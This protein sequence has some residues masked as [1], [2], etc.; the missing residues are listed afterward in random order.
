MQLRK[1]ICIIT[2]A[3]H[4]LKDYNYIFANCSFKSFSGC[5]HI[6]ICNNLFQKDMQVK[7]SVLCIVFIL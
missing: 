6:Y 5:I 7:K 2:Y 4:L 1:K 3:A